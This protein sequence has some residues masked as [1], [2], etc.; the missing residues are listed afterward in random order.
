METK[1]ELILLCKQIERFAKN[2]IVEKPDT[3]NA[4]ELGRA[5]QDLQSVVELSD[6]IKTDR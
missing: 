1:D 5:R 4:Q 3:V 2:P 6:A